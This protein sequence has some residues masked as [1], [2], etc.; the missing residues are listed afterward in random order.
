LLERKNPASNHILQVIV[1]KENLVSNHNLQL[2]TS[3]VHFYCLFNFTNI[4][5]SHHQ[6]SQGIGMDKP[7]FSQEREFLIDLPERLSSLL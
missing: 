4:A 5:F 7:N 6:I 1:R 3:G 2:K